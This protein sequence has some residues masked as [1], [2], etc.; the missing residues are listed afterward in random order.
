[1]GQ[2]WCY[3][4]VATSDTVRLKKLVQRQAKKYLINEHFPES[5]QPFLNLYRQWN[6]VEIRDLDAQKIRQEYV[7]TSIELESLLDIPA[8]KSD[9]PISEPNSTFRIGAISGIDIFPAEWRIECYRTYLPDEVPPQLEIWKHYLDAVRRGEYRAY[10]MQWYLYDEYRNLIEFWQEMRRIVELMA[11]RSNAWVMRLKS[12]S[13]IDDIQSLPEPPTFPVPKWNEW[14]DITDEP[15]QHAEIA[16]KKLLELISVFHSLRK[17]WNS[18]V[19][20]TWKMSTNIQP[21]FDEFLAIKDHPFPDQ[22]F[23]WIEVGIKNG[24][25]LYLWT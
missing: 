20:K 19:P 24:K 18:Q 17:Q 12:T 5:F 7:Q 22:L 9:L 8:L 14:K 2:D 21:T 23:E 1:M 3:M 13:L 11:E 15:D 16:Y 4:D 6:H 25:G 10:L